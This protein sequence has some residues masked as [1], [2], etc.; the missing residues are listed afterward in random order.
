MDSMEI[1]KSTEIDLGNELNFD[2]YDAQL[3]KIAK[4]NTLA[5]FA[6]DTCE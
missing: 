2:R 3:N 6:M 5:K 1:L 4:G